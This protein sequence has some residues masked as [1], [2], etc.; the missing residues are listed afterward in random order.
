MSIKLKTPEDLKDLQT[1][2]KKNEHINEVHFSENGD[3][4]YDKHELTDTGNDKGKGTGKYYGW[5]KTKSIIKTD[6]KGNKR[7]VM[8]SVENP[9]AEI[10]ET[11][12]R[13]EVLEYKPKKTAAE[14]KAEKE[15]DL[16]QD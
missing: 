9:E 5:L 10:I 14:K 2:I 16:Q 3:H 15:N 7:S 11:L 8:G 6:N 1:T 13:Q 12:T 4:Y